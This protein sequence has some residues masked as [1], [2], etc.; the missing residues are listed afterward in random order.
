MTFAVPS[1]ALKLNA[2]FLTT[3]RR[4]ERESSSPVRFEFF[5]HETYLHHHRT[6]RAIRRYLTN[7]TVHPRSDYATY[8]ERL[9]ACDVHLG[10]FPFGGTNSN[11]D[12]MRLGL[13]M[14][15]M[16]GQ[17]SHATGE[18]EMLQRAGFAEW[19]L[20]DDEASY[21]S[22]AL[23]LVHEPEL[24]REISSRLREVDIEGLFMDGG[25][26]EGTG[27][28]GSAVWWLFENRA[29]LMASDKRLYQPDERTEPRAVSMVS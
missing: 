2:K 3:C 10:V 23:R 21:I 17:E 5:H 28:F 4:I 13:P 27:E 25:A 20:A 24:R 11:I 26:E 14:V 19:L 18:T 29:A 6:E 22:A 12:T 1:N 7:V 8:L 9:N 16:R 15:S